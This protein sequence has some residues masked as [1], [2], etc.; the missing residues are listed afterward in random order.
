MNLALIAT[1]AALMLA[2][3]LL[4]SAACITALS[5]LMTTA[6]RRSEAPPP[7]HPGSTMRGYL[8]ALQPPVPLEDHFVTTD[9]G[10]IL[11]LHRLPRPNASVRLSRRS[12]PRRLF[13]TP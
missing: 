11:H 3:R 10:F 12:C 9:D 6:G 5:P 1:A 2:R 4:L 7:I 13:V 8:S